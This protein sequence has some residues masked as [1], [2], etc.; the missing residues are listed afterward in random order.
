MKKAPTHNQT[1]DYSVLTRD[2]LLSIVQEKDEQLE[3]VESTT[4]EQIRCRER[5]IQLLEEKLRLKRARKFAASSEKLPFQIDL[6]DE[7]DMEV[8]LS[9][10][11]SQLPDEEPAK[12]RPKKRKRGFSENLTRKRV[13]LA[14]SEEAKAGA[15]KTF[16]TKVKDELEYIP[17]QL[18]VLEYWQ[19]KAVF[20]ADNEEYIVSAARPIHPLNKCFAHVS[21]LTYIIVAKYADGLPL[22]RLEGILKRYGNPV[23]RT[24]MANWIIRL[25][26]AFKPLIQLI[27]ETQNQG[28]YINADE[29]RIQVLK[30]NGRRA[31]SDKWMWVTCGGPPDKPSVLFEYDP[32]RAGAVPE[33]L[34][35]DFNGILQAD[36]YSGY[37]RICRQNELKR[38]GCWDHARRKFVEAVRAA[39]PKTKKTKGKPSKAD[40][41]VSKIRKLYRIESE[42]AVTVHSETYS[43]KITPRDNLS[44]FFKQTGD[45]YE[46]HK[47]PAPNARGL[48][49]TDSSASRV[50]L[51]R[52]SIL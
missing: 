39:D 42:M 2:Q 33:R 22:Y 9:D 17:A 5:Y 27:R 36:G 19:E 7:V 24:N 38:I 13:E 8:A 44:P 4:R 46:H 51:V 10:L 41:A 43:S 47:I 50:R 26:D 32:T 23:S 35:L 31:Q 30:E 14:L 11:E 37:A 48:A 1:I 6:F 21:L 20:A 45:Q 28:H 18:N 52:R 3:A 29:T 40:I 34:L 12:P 25:D 49:I 15:L 16:F